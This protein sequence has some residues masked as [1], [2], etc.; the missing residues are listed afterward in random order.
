M[1][2]KVLVR[3]ASSSALMR[4]PLNTPYFEKITK[5]RNIM[6][7]YDLWPSIG[8][9]FVA[10]NA[11]VIGEVFL[12][13]DVIIWYNTVL[14]GDINKIR[15][16]DLSVIG[17]HT[18]IHTAASIP[19]AAAASVNIGMN[20]YVGPRCTLYSCTIDDYAW[21]GAGSVVL[22]G[23]RIEK[24]AM[25]APGSVVPPGRLIPAKQLWAGNPVQ[26]VRDLYEP[27]ELALKERLSDERGR[28]SLHQEQFLDIGHAHMYDQ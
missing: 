12:G 20:V 16:L 8:K 1:L 26:Y 23:A 14:R 19:T 27:D 6:P 18:V 15:I 24:G 7:I 25:L 4:V 10:P 21:V 9:S 5:H 28:A 3:L 2:R 13:H 17:E 11:S 22:E